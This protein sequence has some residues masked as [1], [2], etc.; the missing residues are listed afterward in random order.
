M[1]PARSQPE[2]VTKWFKSLII[3]IVYPPKL[4]GRHPVMSADLEKVLSAIQKGAEE[5]LEI[6]KS[7]KKH[8]EQGESS[9][10]LKLIGHIKKVEEEDL[11]DEQ[12]GETEAGAETAA[13]R[14][15]VSGT[16]TAGTGEAGEEPGNGKMEQTNKGKEMVMEET[17]GLKKKPRVTQ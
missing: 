16:E 4:T 9:Q 6:L 15:D 8:I 10:G 11:E 2:N 17:E 14:D 12:K 5:C 13:K 3:N 7:Q 1:R